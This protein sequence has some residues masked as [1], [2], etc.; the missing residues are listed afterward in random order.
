MEAQD[1]KLRETLRQTPTEPGDELDRYWN[2]KSIQDNI[3]ILS[4]LN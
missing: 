2:N 4:E 3:N 1:G